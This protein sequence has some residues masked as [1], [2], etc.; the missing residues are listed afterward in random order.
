[1]QLSGFHGLKFPPIDTIHYIM[2]GL[3]IAGFDVIG[4]VLESFVKRLGNVKDS[5]TFFTGHGGVCDRFDAFYLVAPA[6]VYYLY[7]VVLKSF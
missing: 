5:G 7:F 2:L 4:D 3:I 6:T 1:M